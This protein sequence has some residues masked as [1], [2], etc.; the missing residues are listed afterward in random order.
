MNG[1]VIRVFRS[2]GFVSD[3]VDEG[4]IDDDRVQPNGVDITI[5]KIFT[6]SGAV[7][8]SDEGDYDKGMSRRVRP[9][10]TLGDDDSSQYLLEEG[11]YRVRYGE[12]FRIPE[13]H[14]GYVFPRSRLMRC[15]VMIN[16]ALWD[17]GYEGVGEGLMRVGTTT[18]LPED[19]AVAQFCLI[20]AESTDEIYDGDHQHEGVD[21]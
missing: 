15:G 16:T 17:M 3:H 21:E 19:M 5:D 1:W 12:K 8:L 9:Y 4:D 6:V 11:S 2:G 18:V 7:V 14:V 10:G 13:G 20:N